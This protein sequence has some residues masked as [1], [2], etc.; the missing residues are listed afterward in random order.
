[1]AVLTVGGAAVKSPTE[2][3]AEIFEVGSGDMRS[4]SGMLVR[5]VVAVKR[6][7]HIRWAMLT[8]TELSALLG[9]VGGT[10]FE[11]QYPDPEAGMRTAQFR[12]SGASAGVLRMVE[13][14]PVWTDVVMEWTER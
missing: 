9:K 3:R 13:G 7:L 11:A 2:L 5:D 4:A 10:A 8:P 1:M 6:R 12:L 14:A